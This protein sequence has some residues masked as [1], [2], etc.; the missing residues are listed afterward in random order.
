MKS[1]IKVLENLK[2]AVTY[3]I[4]NNILTTILLYYIILC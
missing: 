4:D 1:N 3:L 2:N